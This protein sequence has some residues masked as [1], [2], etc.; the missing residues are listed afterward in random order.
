M[1]VRFYKRQRIHPQ[2]LRQSAAVAV[3]LLLV[4]VVVN[5]SLFSHI[6]TAKYI[7]I[8][9]A[10]E[11]INLVTKEYGAITYAQKKKHHKESIGKRVQRFDPQNIIRYAANFPEPHPP[12]KP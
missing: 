9:L 11:F 4:S 7:I 12:N 10:T 2:F 5:S 8:A 1:N 6:S 3:V